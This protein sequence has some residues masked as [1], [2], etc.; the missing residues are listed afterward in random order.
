MKEDKTDRIL[1][2]VLAFSESKGLFDCGTVVVGLSG[3]PD[4]VALICILKE[5]KDRNDIS[6]DIR[7]FHCNH[8][9]RPVVCDE[10]AEQVRSLCESLGVDLKVIDFDC[11]GFAESNRI[12]EET[13]GRLLR[14]EAFAATPHPM[15]WWFP[16]VRST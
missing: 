7:A 9:L 2:R 14:Y 13:A 1:D 12:S 8:H 11:K 6:C 16:I 4:S 5:L 3:G 15:E 10:E